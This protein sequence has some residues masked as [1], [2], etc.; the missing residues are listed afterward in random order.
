MSDYK[1][2]Y[3]GDFCQRQKDR[4]KTWATA[5]EYHAE[6]KINRV[7]YTSETMFDNCPTKNEN[8]RINCERY[9]RYLYITNNVKQNAKQQ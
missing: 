2:P 4:I 3:D 5:V 7:F 9:R 1:C 8:V 6:N